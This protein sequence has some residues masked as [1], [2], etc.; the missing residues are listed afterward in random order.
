MPSKPK[1]NLEKVRAALNTVCSNC[2]C[3]ITPAEICRIDSEKI[4]C[5]RC[6]AKFAPSAKL[7]EA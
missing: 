6:G 3:A 7:R 1:I 2:A 4:K 5:P